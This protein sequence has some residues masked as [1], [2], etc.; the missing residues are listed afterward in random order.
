MARTPVVQGRRQVSNAHQALPRHQP[1]MVMATKGETGQAKFADAQ[2]GKRKRMRPRTPWTTPSTTSAARI[3]G[4]GIAT[5]PKPD[6]LALSRQAPERQVV[7][8][9]PPTLCGPQQQRGHHAR[10]D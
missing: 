3:K 6:P 8:R 2:D 9:Y 4:E 5:P 10:Q 7:E 1:P